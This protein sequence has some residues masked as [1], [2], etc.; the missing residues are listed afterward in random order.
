MSCPVT[1]KK[2]VRELS[3]CPVTAKRAVCELLPCPAPAK[4]A[5]YELSSSP[6]PATEAAY[7]SMSC[8]VMA[9]KAACDSSSCPVTATEVVCESRT[10]SA[11]AP[12]TRRLSLCCLSLFSQC[13]LSLLS[14]CCWSLFSYVCR[15]CQGDLPS[16]PRSGG[17]WLRLFPPWGGS[18]SI[19]SVLGVYS[20]VGSAL[21]GS[22]PLCSAQESYSPVGSAL[23]GSRSVCSA[24]GGLS[25]SARPWWAPVPSAPPRWAPGP[26]A[27]PWRASVRSALPWWAPVPSSP[28][29]LPH[30]PGPPSLPLFRLR[31]TAHLVMC[32]SVW[33]PLLGGGLC[34]ES[35]PWTLLHS[36]PEVTLTSLDSHTVTD[37]P[38]RLHLP[39][40]TA[41]SQLFHIISLH[42]FTIIQSPSHYINPEHSA[43]LC[44]VLLASYPSKAFS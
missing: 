42:L 16:L 23:V 14:L 31:S 1:A 22:S 33:K 12:E 44:R 36:P 34:H 9:V 15:C 21:V 43:T 41:P 28:H 39:S 30:G 37:H 27:P 17:S 32:R 13:C 2:A 5:A 18:R 6:A 20:P 7:D 24:L 10:C 3:P 40:F 19:C 8:P 29:C 25:R 26:S 38:L 4:K 11:T 35:K